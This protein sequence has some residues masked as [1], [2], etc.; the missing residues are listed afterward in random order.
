MKK[1]GS[2]GDFAFHERC[3]ALKLNHLSFADDV[4]LFC[5]GDYKSIILLLQGLKLF[6]GTSGLQPNKT[7][8]TIY[9]S[10]MVDSDVARVMEASGFSKN[11]H[12]SDILVFPYAPKK[13]RDMSALFRQQEFGLGALGTFHLLEGL[14]SLIRF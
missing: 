9:F 5:R 12:H 2:K 4:L 10:N 3:E 7:K 14:F 13:Y 11:R 8:S 6:S 1:V